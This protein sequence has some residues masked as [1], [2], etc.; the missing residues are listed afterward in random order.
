MS[1]S[2]SNRIAVSPRFEL[3]FALAAVLDAALPMPADA[4]AARWLVHARR[5]LDPG[6]RRRLG[7]LASPAIWHRLAILPGVAALDGETQGV[8]DA[9]ADL[10]PLA[11]AELTDDSEALQSAAIDTLRRFDRLAFAAFWR[12]A[13]PRFTAAAQIRSLDRDADAQADETIYFSSIFVPPD[14][15]A[16]F[17]SPTGS[18]IAVRF[19]DAA[20][21]ADLAA[22]TLTAEFPA[23]R[24]QPRAAADPALIFRALGDATRY[25]IARLIAQDVLTGADLARRLGVSGP[26]LTH[27]IRQLREAG[28]VQEERRG[29]R[30]L[31]RLDRR[32]IDALSA[33]A[34]ADLFA[35]QPV[36]IRRSRKG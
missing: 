14:Y 24:P 15:A 30:I 33:A 7:D 28:L 35:G 3:F 26:T 8:I 34:A 12:S 27:H 18:R 2:A 22:R 21:R 11:F 4:S 13:A 32:T 31:L 10:P 9:L 20:E 36:A 17:A 6:F 5:K 16:M 29:N 23:T 19:L 25:A 1:H